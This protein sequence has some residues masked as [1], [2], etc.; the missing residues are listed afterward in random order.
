MKRYIGI[1]IVIIGVILIAIGSVT[2]VGEFIYN[3]LKTNLGFIEIMWE[4]LK[5]WLSLNIIGVSL[6]ITGAAIME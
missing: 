3:L 6:Y 5:T 2:A 1:A 4:S